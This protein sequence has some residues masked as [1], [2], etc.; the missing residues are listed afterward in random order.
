MNEQIDPALFNRA[1]AL[2]IHHGKASTSFVQRHL[3]IGFNAASRLI[4]RMEEMGIVSAPDHVGKREVA[5][6][7]I[8]RAAIEIGEIARK[9]P[10]GEREAF[11]SAINDAIDPTSIAARIEKLRS[12]GKMGASACAIAHHLGGY[13]P[14]EDSCPHDAADFE[15]CELLLMY[16][17]EFE[18]QFSRMATVSRYWAALVPHW[19]DLRATMRGKRTDAMKAILDPIIDADPNA[20]RLG[21]GITI[22]SQIVA[23]MRAAHEAQRSKEGKPKM[24]PDPT[25]DA[26]ANNAY[27]VTADELRQFIERFEQLEAE[28]KDIAEQQK[29][30]MA[31]AKGR[32]YDTK[33]IRQIIA[34]RKRK[35]DD[36]AEEQA[37]LELYKSA[38]GMV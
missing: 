10:D 12:C 1:A 8:I 11:S 33:V 15:R 19:T 23:G 18:A 3:G 16:V 35:A 21:Q 22:H 34:L 17:P 29:E 5:T 13:G 4:E 6:V 7:E 2:V 26:A 27:A 24:K 14:K 32:G 37:I 38:L 9:L 31:E 25:F 30:V 28:K 36:L 20:I